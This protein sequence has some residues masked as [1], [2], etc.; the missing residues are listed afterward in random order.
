[1]IA[2]PTT[3]PD[4]LVIEPKVFNPDC[5]LE[6]E[7]VSMARASKFAS[8]RRAHNGVYWR[9]AGARRFADLRPQADVFAVADD[10][11]SS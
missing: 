2:T 3:I 10:P 5:P 9:G 8:P 11:K 6:H 1:M 7:R 4:V